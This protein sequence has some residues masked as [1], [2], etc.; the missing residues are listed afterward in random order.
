M[1][2]YESVKNN[3]KEYLKYVPSQGM[4]HQY[5]YTKIL[6]GTSIMK[7]LAVIA[8]ELHEMNSKGN[9]NHEND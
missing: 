8:D 1:S 5:D 9:V 3:A 6:I 7:L 4:T 2:Y